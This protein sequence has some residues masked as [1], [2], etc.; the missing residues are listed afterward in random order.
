MNLKKINIFLLSGSNPE[1]ILNL[2]IGLR[3]IL[4]ERDAIAD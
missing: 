4:Y 1:F 3:K 2:V